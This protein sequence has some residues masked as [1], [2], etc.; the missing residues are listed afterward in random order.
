[1]HV[2][3]LAITP[4]SVQ[5]C[6]D[7][8]ELVLCDKVTDASLVLGS[9]VRRDGVEVEFEGGSEWRNNGDKQCQEAQYPI[10][11]GLC[12]LQRVCGT[13]CGVDTVSQRASACPVVRT[14]VLS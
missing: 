12:A 13:T 6:C 1:M 8:H 5:D 7:D 3:L 11:G 4:V 9:I 2:D 10:H 14:G